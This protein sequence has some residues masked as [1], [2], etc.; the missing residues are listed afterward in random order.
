MIIFC[1]D[2]R[3]ECKRLYDSQSIAKRFVRHLH[4]AQNAF[5]NLVSEQSDRDWPRVMFGESK[6][7]RQ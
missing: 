6:T 2:A 7:R 5:E 3:G 1:L 4:I